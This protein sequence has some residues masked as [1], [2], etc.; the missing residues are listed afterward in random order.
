[1]TTFKSYGSS[2]ES[3]DDS[4]SNRSGSSLSFCLIYEISRFYRI[5]EL[6]FV[7]QLKNKNRSKN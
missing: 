1:M 7:R 3:D 4:D 5:K 6:N 2:S